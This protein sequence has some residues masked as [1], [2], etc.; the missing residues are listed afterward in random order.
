MRHDSRPLVLVTEPRKNQS[1]FTLLE[2]LIASI[3]FAIMA[4]MAYG[5]LDNVIKNSSSSKQALK[6]LQ[7]IQQSVAVMDRDFSQILQRSIRDEY[8]NKQPYLKASETGDYLIE[9]TR[10]GRVNPANL[11]RS[12]L[13]RVAYRYDDNKLHRIQWP[14]LDRAQGIEPRETSIIDNVSDVTFRF[15]DAK[16]EWQDQW[17]PLNASDTDDQQ[18]NA[19]QPAALEVVMTLEDWGDIR[20]LYSLK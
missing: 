20:R 3:I 6:R 8:G 14:Q 18:P 11:L 5:G 12:S 7:Q 16:G 2:L 1:G 15:L 17:P 4:L 9:L 10:G 13:L 19:N